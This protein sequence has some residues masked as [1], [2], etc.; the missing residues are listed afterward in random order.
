MKSLTFSVYIFSTILFS[1][2]VLTAQASAILRNIIAKGEQQAAKTIIRE[3]AEAIAK[4][5][6]HLA[7]D[8]TL[9]AVNSL[10]ASK[11]L[12]EG[13]QNNIKKFWENNQDKVLD[14]TSNL[15]Q[16]IL[17]KNE[18]SDKQ[19]KLY[20]DEIKAH[21]NYPNLYKAICRKIKKDTA[22]TVEANALLLGYKLNGIG[23]DSNKLY[24]VYFTFS[25]TFAKE[26]LEKMIGFYNC[27]E[28]KI[29]EIVVIGQ[30]RN[31]SLNKNICKDSE[32]EGGLFEAILGLGFLVF[33]GYI[34][35]KVYIFLKRL[36]TSKNN[37]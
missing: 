37:P 21:V 26:E 3:E 9:P 36:L 17:E 24:N 20:L 1:S 14:G 34:L 33:I 11:S 30:K 35:Y 2:E 28:S 32:T 25:N 10:K 31:I 8:V 6:T 19:K 27:D 4:A 5:S 15:I 29:Q 16:A 18:E 12:A 13:Y 7:D 23:I 22:T